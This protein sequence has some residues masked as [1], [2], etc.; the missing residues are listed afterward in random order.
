MG[1]PTEEDPFANALLE[2]I[3]ASQEAEAT[4]RDIA[5]V[6]RRLAMSVQR[7]TTDL[8]AVTLRP[9]D[10]SLREA[11]NL[12][13][14]DTSDRLAEVQRNKSVPG[15]PGRLAE[16]R[17]GRVGVPAAGKVRIARLKLGMSG[18][19]VTIYGPH[20]EMTSRTLEGL[21]EQLL[22]LL[23]HP[24]VGKE[25][26]RIHSAAVAPKRAAA[27]GLT[28]ALRGVLSKHTQKSPSASEVLTRS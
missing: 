15:W 21:E 16:L 5:A 17:V 28:K 23:R 20:M 25:I 22:D 26:Q 10:A 2:G 3:A 19:P 4:K 1:D 7:S 14:D 12:T 11:M 27:L 6:F 9:S 8:V 13:I 24:T 18:F